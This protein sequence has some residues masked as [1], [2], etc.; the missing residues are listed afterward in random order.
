MR[1]WQNSM[2][3]NHLRSRWQVVKQGASGDDAK[4]TTLGIGTKQ[5]GVL[6]PKLHAPPA[7]E[8]KAKGAPIPAAKCHAVN[9]PLPNTA[10]TV[11][12]EASAKPKAAPKP[13]ALHALR[14]RVWRTSSAQTLGKADRVR[15]YDAAPACHGRGCRA[16]PAS[17]SQSARASAH[18]SRASKALEAQ[19]S[20]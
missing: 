19:Q 1:V 16:P 15:A 6:R 12:T 10:H 4:D 9:I 5:Q 20:G 14:K 13:K 2:C 8:K 7:I 18:L 3:T 11:G 17:I